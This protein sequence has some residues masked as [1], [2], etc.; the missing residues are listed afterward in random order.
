[1]AHSPLVSNA[2]SVAHRQ[3]EGLFRPNKNSDP[4]HTH[5]DEVALLVEQSGG[6]D[7]EI[8][9]A[10]LHDTVEDTDLTIADIEKNFGP[11]V[12][13]IVDG[14]TDKPDITEL[15]LLQ[16]K[17]IQA[18]RVQEK[19]ASVKRCKL[20]DQIS[21]VRSVAIDPPVTWSAQKCRDYVTGAKCIADACKGV[22]AYLD[23][24][25]E[26]AYQKACA[27]YPVAA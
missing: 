8:A 18:E 9:A 11:V 2:K 26:N 15:P 6:S 21:N 7:I 25:F 1:M 27:A 12:A 3:H 23:A 10:H 24:E 14:L 17:V 5:T 20:A 19:S 13:L 22:S 16:R 4:Y